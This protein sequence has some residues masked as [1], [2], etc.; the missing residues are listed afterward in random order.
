MGSVLA[1]AMSF[2]KEGVI[3]VLCKEFPQ[4]IFVFKS[5]TLEIIKVTGYFKLSIS[6]LLF[7]TFSFFNS[8]FIN[9][10]WIF[11]AHYS[12]G[13]MSKH[14]VASDKKL[15]RDKSNDSTSVQLHC[16]VL[17][18]LFSGVWMK[19]Y[20]QQKKK[21]KDSDSCITKSQPSRVMAR[22]TW[23]L[24][25]HCT[26]CRQLDRWSV[27]SKQPTWPIFYTVQLVWKCL[28]AILI[29]YLCLGKEGP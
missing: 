7:W 13:D 14:I 23:K 6:T 27:I 11:V 17:L 10:Y 4:R 22:E 15:V 29:G 1:N 2:S 3:R 25:V 21:K 5:L 8:S 16:G 24:G 20:L 12:W 19:G 26:H 9:I 28:S 18:G